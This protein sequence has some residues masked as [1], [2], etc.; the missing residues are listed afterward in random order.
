[1]YSNFFLSNIAN[2]TH[3]TENSKTLSGN[4]FTHNY[5]PSFFLGNIVTTLS[6]HNYNPSFFLGNIVTTL[7]DHNYNPSFFLGNIVTTLSDHNDQLKLGR[8]KIEITNYS[9][10]TVP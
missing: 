5:K 2:P 4:I 1:M 10:T 9:D 7:S 8:V 6:D 3:I